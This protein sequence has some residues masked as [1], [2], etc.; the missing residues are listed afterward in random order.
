M[1][2]VSTWRELLA[3]P[4][5]SSDEAEFNK[6]RGLSMAVPATATTRAFRT[7]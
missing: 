1:E 3:S 5:G 7:G 6:S 4:S 2:F